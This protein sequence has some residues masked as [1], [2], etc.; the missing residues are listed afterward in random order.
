MDR[1]A[2]E[3]RAELE[4]RLEALVSRQRVAISKETLGEILYEAAEIRWRLG[5]ISD[6]EFAEAEDFHDSFSFDF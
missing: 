2:D 1:A 6:E 4:V 5:L 3:Q